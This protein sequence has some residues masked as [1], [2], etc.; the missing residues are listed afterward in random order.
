MLAT[1]GIFHYKF[2]AHLEKNKPVANEFLNGDLGSKVASMQRIIA[3]K[4]YS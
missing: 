4:L 2:I 3:V 1:K